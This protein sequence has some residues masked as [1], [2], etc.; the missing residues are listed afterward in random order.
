LGNFGR[1]NPELVSDRYQ[2]AGS[3]AND[4]W[5]CHDCSGHIYTSKRDSRPITT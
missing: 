5:N 1:N 3:N 4:W 2:A